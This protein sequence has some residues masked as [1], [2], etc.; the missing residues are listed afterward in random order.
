LGIDF[1]LVAK[2]FEDHR[3]VNLSQAAKRQGAP[4][5]PLFESRDAISRLYA[6]AQVQ[7]P[8]PE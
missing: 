6:T 2:P 3:I 4:P 7:K 1:R 8:D 5:E